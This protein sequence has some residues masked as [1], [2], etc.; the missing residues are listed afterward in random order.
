MSKVLSLCC[1]HTCA[2]SSLNNSLQKYT[3]V[4]TYS[5]LVLI[6]LA[7]NCSH[8]STICSISIYSTNR[9]NGIL[10]VLNIVELSNG[11]LKTNDLLQ[12]CTATVWTTKINVE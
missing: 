11:I 6:T 10:V 2:S 5:T 3:S 1:S 8:T 4:A 7:K 12:Y 9:C